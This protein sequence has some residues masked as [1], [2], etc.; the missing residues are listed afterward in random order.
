MAKKKAIKRKQY[1]YKQPELKKMT[2]Q[3]K[4]WA[5]IAA[6]AAV[7]V[8]LFLAIVPL[9]GSMVRIFGNV[10]GLKKNM[11][12]NNTGTTSKPHYYDLGSVDFEKIPMTL[13]DDTLKS[14]P[15]AHDFYLKSEDGP[16]DIVYISGT[17]YQLD[18]LIE[19][20]YNQNLA[21]YTEENLTPIQKMTVGDKEITYFTF[22][23]EYSEDDVAAA[24]AEGD[25]LTPNSTTAIYFEGKHGFAVVVTAQNSYTDRAEATSEEEIINFVAENVLPA[26]SK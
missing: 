15:N 2:P 14:D 24:A 22:Y 19:K 18:A 12:T 11:I 23:V 5:I 6:A 9:D 16:V 10:V 8:I 26:I 17:S 1:T 20:V 4:K 3:Q 25:V 7:V 13:T 21:S